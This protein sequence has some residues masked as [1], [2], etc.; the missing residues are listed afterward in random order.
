LVWKITLA[1]HTPLRFVLYAWADHPLAEPWLAAALALW[2]AVAALELPELLE[3][4]AA[5]A[6]AAT[7]EVPS[8]SGRIGK[9][10]P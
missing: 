5:R 10:I 4:H 9:R 2:L 6:S 8:S 1:G 7:A 3:P